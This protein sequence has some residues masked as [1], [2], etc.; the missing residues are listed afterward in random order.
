M[1]MPALKDIRR[2]WMMV[3]MVP[4][5]NVLLP[6]AIDGTSWSMGVYRAESSFLDYK[7]DKVLC[8]L[9]PD[10]SISYWSS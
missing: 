8:L 9:L 10:G 5:C 2:I 3:F 1:E 7:N 4:V 6:T